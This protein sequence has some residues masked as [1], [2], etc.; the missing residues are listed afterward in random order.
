MNYPDNFETPA[1]P[2]GTRIATSR[3]AAIGIAVVYAL[4]VFVCGVLLWSA[5]SVRISPFL[6][7]T[8]EMPNEWRIV[9][10]DGGTRRMPAYRTLQEALVAKYIQRRFYISA[11]GAENENL[12]TACARE[13]DCTTVGNT[14]TGGDCSLFCA[15]TSDEFSEFQTAVVPGYMERFEMGEHWFVNSASIR[16]APSGTISAS[17]GMWRAQFTIITNMGAPIQVVAY[18]KVARNMQE[19]PRTMGYYIANFNAY[20]LD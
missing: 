19:Y 6:V 10:H 8:N 1:F 4:I 15:T 16:M 7:A 12:W 20:R 3:A 17:G 14:S 9:G 11:I 18:A 5:R 13:T 2:A